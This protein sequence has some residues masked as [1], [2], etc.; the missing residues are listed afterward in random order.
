MNP[1]FH[2]CIVAM[3]RSILLLIF[4]C[5]VLGIDGAAG[6]EAAAGGNDCSICCEPIVLED[7]VRLLDILSQ[8]G[9]VQDRVVYT[10]CNH[11]YHEGCLRGWIINK[12][13]DDCPM[14]R[15]SMFPVADQRV[16]EMVEQG[17]LE[18]I[19]DD[20][21]ILRYR[22]TGGIGG[23]REFLLEKRPKFLTSFGL[24]I[25]SLFSFHVTSSLSK[26]E[27]KAASRRT[28]LVGILLLPSAFA[29]ILGCAFVSVFILMGRIHSIFT[30]RYVARR[31]TLAR[32]YISVISII[33][34]FCCMDFYDE[35]LKL[36]SLSNYAYIAKALPWV[37]MAT[38][39]I[40]IFYCIGR[41]NAR[42]VL[43]FIVVFL[44]ASFISAIQAE[45]LRRSLQDEPND[46]GVLL[47]P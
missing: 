43:L 33:H 22:H 17:L 42:F 21:N 12:H 30:L 47:V 4:L 16:V 9:Q 11:H 1:G 26:M 31:V 7:P 45:V 3:N 40:Q 35:F 29:I 10:E 34:L 18:P 6:T 32:I 14:C 25:F 24:F 27:P 46:M 8:F 28:F 19:I 5:F 23:T 44:I 41:R 20:N 36:C 39:L 37:S 2:F 13:R 15:G 38:V